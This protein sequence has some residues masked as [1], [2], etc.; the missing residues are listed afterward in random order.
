MVKYFEASIILKGG[1]IKGGYIG[2]NA[3]EA[4]DI[5]KDIVNTG[6]LF[7]QPVRIRVARCEL[8]CEKTAQPKAEEWDLN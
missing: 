4:Y 2:D 7:P 8:V 6:E 3:K 5:A 1:E